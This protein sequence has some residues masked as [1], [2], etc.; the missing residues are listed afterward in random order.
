MEQQQLLLFDIDITQLFNRADIEQFVCVNNYIGGGTECSVYR[1]TDTICFKHY[2]YYAPKKIDDIFTL[3]QQMAD[4]DLA[5]KVYQLFYDGYTTEIIQSLMRGI[6]F[7]C[8]DNVENCNQI[9]NAL[10]YENDIAID[11]LYELTDKLQS[12]YSDFS[13]LHNENIGI[14]NGKLV[15]IDFGLASRC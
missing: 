13:D 14:K 5:P 11:E 8:D 10:L 3:A 15:A 6:C 7:G 9:C 12:L 2:P 1:I 4:Y